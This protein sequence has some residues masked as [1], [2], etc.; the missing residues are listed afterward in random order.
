LEAREDY[1]LNGRA[2]TREHALVERQIAEKR[3]TEWEGKEREGGRKLRLDRYRDPGELQHERK[4][5][6]GKKRAHFWGT[7]AVRVMGVAGYELH[8]NAAPG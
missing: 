2:P 8:R 3:E 7:L 5:E 6:R 1:W 4:N